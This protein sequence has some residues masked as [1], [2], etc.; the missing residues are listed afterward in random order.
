MVGS[1]T[2]LSR[3][4][5]SCEEEIKIALSRSPFY[6]ICHQLHCALIFRFQLSQRDIEELLF[7]RGVVVSYE[8]IRRRCD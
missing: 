1:V 7:K 4:R 5:K 8:T 3:S 6:G 2:L